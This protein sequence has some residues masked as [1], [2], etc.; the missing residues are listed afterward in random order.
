[1]LERNWQEVAGKNREEIGEGR[2]GK[3]IMCETEDQILIK[4]FKKETEKK[5][6]INVNFFG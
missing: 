4:L 1:M 3:Y 6:K 5:Q 2:S